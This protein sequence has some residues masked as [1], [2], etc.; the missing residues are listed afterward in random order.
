MAEAGASPIEIAAAMKSAFAAAGKVR[1]SQHSF[2][3]SEIHHCT[4]LPFHKFTN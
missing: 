3:N 1:C 2:T 4:N